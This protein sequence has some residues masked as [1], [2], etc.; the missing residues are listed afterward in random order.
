M[1]VSGIIFLFTFILQNDHEHV[2]VHLHYLS[3]NKSLFLIYSIKQIVEDAERNDGS[4]QRPYY[5]SR[6]LMKILAKR[7]QGKAYRSD[8]Q[9]QQLSYNND[10]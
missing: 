3:L 6:R 7:T 8:A 2:L 4:M 5:M 9:G 10:F 1:L